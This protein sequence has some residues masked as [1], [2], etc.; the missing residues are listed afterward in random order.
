MKNS[1]AILSFPVLISSAVFAQS[2]MP[3]HNDLDLD[4]LK[5]NVIQVTDRYYQVLQTTSGKDS[6]GQQWEGTDRNHV[7]NYDLRGNITSATF[8]KTGSIL[9]YRYT[10]KYDDA[11]NRIEETWFDSDN[12]L[13]YRLTRKFSN[14]GFTME[15]KKFTDT[16]EGY[17][18]KYVYEPDPEGRPVTTTLY[19]ENDEVIQVTKSVY[20]GFGN[21]IEDD[22]FDGKGKSRGKLLY[23]YDGKRLKTS[24]E[25]YTASGEIMTKKKFTYEYRGKLSQQQ[26]FDNNGKLVEKNIFNYNENG[27]QS[28]WNNYDRTGFAIYNYTYMYEYDSK[29]NWISQTTFRGGKAAFITVRAIKYY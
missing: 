23:T 18:E 10:F 24:E 13:D 14:K 20:D 12:E 15:T 8:Y 6:M 27:D 19:D 29:G 17:T 7:T 3:G 2:K 4:N 9:D 1:L 28:D 21:K 25:A 26:N 5:G 16:T 22:N 11:G